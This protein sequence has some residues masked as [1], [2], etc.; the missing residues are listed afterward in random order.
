MQRLQRN[1][2][3]AHPAEGSLPEGP[4]QRHQS[5]RLR[6]QQL[7]ANKTKETRTAACQ[8]KVHSRMKSI[9]AK[10]ILIILMFLL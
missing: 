6:R 7:R 1:V 5:L 9:F 2:Y 8:T 3:A 10:E 4:R